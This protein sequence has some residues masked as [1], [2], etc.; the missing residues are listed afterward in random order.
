MTKKQRL[1]ELLNRLSDD[2]GERELLTAISAALGEP[3]SRNQRSFGGV[4]PLRRAELPPGQTVQHDISTQDTCIEV[5]SAPDREEHR[6]YQG[7][8]RSVDA[9]ILGGRVVAY[10]IHWFTGG[11]SRWFVPGVN[12][13]D[14]KYNDS[15]HAANTA[16]HNTLRRMWSYFHD[17]EHRYLLIKQ[18]DRE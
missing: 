15:G 1:I 9:E 3:A 7:L 16:S 2:A 6:W 4:E 8:S 5:K 11:W 13:I 14:H 12:D 18:A 10:Q 17:H